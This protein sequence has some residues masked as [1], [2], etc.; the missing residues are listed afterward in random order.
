MKDEDKKILERVLS[1]CTIGDIAYNLP[2]IIWCNIDPRYEL[3][4]R[5]RAKIIMS[6]P[7]GSCTASVEMH[8]GWNILTDWD[9]HPSIDEWDR[10]W[11]WTLAPDRK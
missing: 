4:G 7:G 8:H 11:Y 5:K 1:E 10:D 2:S 6:I 9:L 3:V